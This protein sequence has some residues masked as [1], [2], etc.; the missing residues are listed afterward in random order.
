MTPVVKPYFPSD[1][2]PSN[3]RN[4][5]RGG[6]Y[7]PADSSHHMQ[8]SWVTE[9]DRTSSLSADSMGYMK[10]LWSCVEIIW[11]PGLIVVYSLRCIIE[12]I[13]IKSISE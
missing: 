3:P 11:V 6:K 2:C 5:E 8:N 4:L 12:S 10:K 13:Q 9:Y 1:T 7:G